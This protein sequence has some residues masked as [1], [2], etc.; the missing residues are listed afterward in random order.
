MPRYPL[1]F[2][3][4]ADEIWETQGTKKGRKMSNDDSC[5]SGAPWS[6]ELSNAF[7][8]IDSAAQHWEEYSEDLDCD[9]LTML[10]DFA[11]DS[12]VGWRFIK[13]SALISLRSAVQAKL[14]ELD[15]QKRRAETE[16]NCLQAENSRLYELLSQRTD[17]NRGE[18]K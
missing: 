4:T 14:I 17:G 16:L 5:S 18:Q 2:V 1:T 13:N 11:V 3:K 6:V 7:E 8:K 12:V 9:D 15:H 10:R